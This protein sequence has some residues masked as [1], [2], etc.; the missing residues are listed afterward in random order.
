MPDPDRMN[1]EKITVSLR[2]RIDGM[3]AHHVGVLV[4]HRDGAIH[5]FTMVTGE[6]EHVISYPYVALVWWKEI[7][8]P[9]AP[10]HTPAE[11]PR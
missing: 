11:L 5:L 7:D 8:T 9:D 6:V 2:Q 10:W 4:L 3:R 1:H